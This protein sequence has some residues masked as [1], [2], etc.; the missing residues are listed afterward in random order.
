VKDREFRAWLEAKSGPSRLTA[1]A[2][3]NRMS[4]ARR[5]ERALGDLDAAYVQDRLEG[6]LAA[7]RYTKAD[8][9]AGRRPLQVLVPSSAQPYGQMAN[10]KNA[11]QHYRQM[12]D[13]LAG[14]P[15]WP[16]LD[17]MRD[18]F[19][20]KC[21]DFESFEQAYGAYFD[22]ERAYKDRLLSEVKAV[23][24]DDLSDVET[25]K[26]LLKLLATG[27]GA[28]VRWQARDDIEKKAGEPARGEMLAA[29][30]ALARQTSE[31]PAACAGAARHLEALRQQS[32]LQGPGPADVLSIVTSVIGVAHP[33]GAVPVRKTAGQKAAAALT[34]NP[35]F[36]AGVL[37]EDEYATYLALIDRVFQVMRDQ[38]RWR[39]RDWFDVQGFLWV[40]TDDR[41]RPAVEDA[42]EEQMDDPKAA[43]SPTN[44]ILYGPPGTGKTYRTAER[45][46][47][48]CDGGPPAGGRA[49]TMVR[50]RE[51]VESKRISFVTFHQSYAYEDF[52]EGLRPEIGSNGDGDRV[53]GGF[54]LVP[55]PGVFR[56]IAELARDNRGRAVSAP[57]I[58]ETRQAFKMSL[59]RRN[60]EED[61]RI[62]RE[63]LE[64]GYVV[65]GYGG[66]IDW[67]PGQ[68]DDFEAIKARWQQDHPEATG[69]DAN[70]KQL[71]A[72]RGGMKIG[73]LVIIS[74]GNKTF[75]AVGEV[76]GPY[77]FVPGLRREYNHRRSVRWLWQ[78]DQGLPRELIYAREFIQVSAY[79]LDSKA[80]NWPAL[81]QVVA[82]GGDAAATTGA[83]E[84]YVLIID[85]INRANVSKVFGE[86][87]TLIEPDKRLGADNA[88]TVTLPYSGDSFGVPANL[89]IVGTMNTA[90][91]SIALLDTA[92][93]RRFEF[94]ELLPDASALVDASRDAGLDLVAVLEGLNRRIEYLFDRDHQIGH[95]FFIG[96]KT[97]GDVARVMRTKVI[98]LLAEYFYEDWE[99]VRQVLGE[100]TDAGVFVGRTRLKPP[101]DDD[102][103]EPDQGRWRYGVHADFPAV[104]YDQLKV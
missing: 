71:Y 42:D 57:A 26:A 61:A 64:G 12:L 90:D 13:S 41:W 72:L 96:C 38:W 88:L 40:V 51:L 103:F 21:P 54:S 44:L 1:K 34:G 50:Y 22:D 49:A 93:R 37:A 20:D 66:E 97:A 43:A 14:A 65:L 85:E 98:P 15:Q 58:D 16:E 18:R 77:Q 59:G 100:S 86:L 60:D 56:Q 5:A 6:V 84:A 2:I 28:L 47:A 99:K 81:K 55:R 94:E 10:I 95:A 46:V 17:A 24:A 83:P 19:L 80:I 89:H 32:G 76:I 27:D 82:G 102:A 104:A 29:I 31:F 35:V 70:V 39:P 92:L 101:K 69:N 63:A 25:G 74:D 48:L 23:L 45:A 73:D 3:N 36:V 62:Y 7:L 52:V 53:S 68:Y 4:R 78:S 79:Q 11:I 8:Q 75:R 91:R 87:I 9:Q 30:G 67:S 33:S